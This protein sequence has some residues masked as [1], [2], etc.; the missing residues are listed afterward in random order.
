MLPYTHMHRPASLRHYRW[1]VAPA[2]PDDSPLRA[3]DEGVHPILR[4]ILYNRGLT[5]P[6]Q[7]QTF[8]ANHYLS[9]RDPF[10]LADMED[11]PDS[12]SER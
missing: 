4:Q 3:A 8:L 11:V 7:I 10:L 1:L 5:Q 9:S 2:I 6:G 12:M